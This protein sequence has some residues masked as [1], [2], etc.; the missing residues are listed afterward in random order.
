M[1][2]MGVLTSLG[3]DQLWEV[4]VRDSAVVGCLFSVRIGG[5]AAGKR[6]IRHLGGNQHGKR[7]HERYYLERVLMNK[8]RSHPRDFV[9]VAEQTTHT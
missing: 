1:G 2:M 4:R 5:M 7:H 6:M 9:V 3:I 8:N